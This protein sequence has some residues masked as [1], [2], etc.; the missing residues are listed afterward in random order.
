[1][2]AVG[3]L[4]AAATTNYDDD[5]DRYGDMPCTCSSDYLLGVSESSIDDEQVAGYGSKS[6]ELFAPGAS[7]STR[8]SNNYGDF[9]GTSGASPHIAGA[10]AL[11]YS[12]Q[13]IGW[14][15]MIQQ[16]PQKAALLVKSILLNSVDKDP[17]FEK[18]VS[19]GRLNLG[20]A[21]QELAEYFSRPAAGELISIF[22][23]PVKDILTIKAALAYEGEHPIRIYNTAGQPVAV[24]SL[25][26][27]APTIRY[28]DFDI[29]H[30]ARGMYI[31]ELETDSKKYIQKFVKY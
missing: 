13:N 31:L 10:I 17:E 26:S 4:S 3:I 18:S 9:G 30:L 25:Q 19:G 20:R 2:G 22:P 6:V 8:W 24:F 15:A 5:I 28:W 14:S 29:E 16:S 21:M 11:L 23:S 27:N 1:L 12:Y 7:K